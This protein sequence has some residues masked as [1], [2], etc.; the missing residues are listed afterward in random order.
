MQILAMV[1]A[2]RRPAHGR[3]KLFRRE[4]CEVSSSSF[5]LVKTGLLAVIRVGL[6]RLRLPFSL[7]RWHW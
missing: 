3:F 4:K 7:M 2:V 1:G 6:C 5:L